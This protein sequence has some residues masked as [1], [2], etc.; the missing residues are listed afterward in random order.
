MKSIYRIL[1]CLIGTG[2]ATT[3]S[4]NLN[5]AGIDAETAKTAAALRD[6]VDEL[7]ALDQ[8]FSAAEKI[9]SDLQTQLRDL[10]RDIAQLSLDLS[11]GETVARQQ[12]QNIDAT[13]K[14]IAAL[15]QQ[16]EAQTTSIKA[17]LQAAYRL[18]GDSLAKSLMQTQSPAEVD[19]LIRY[20]GYF[21][22]HRIDLVE[23][24]SGTLTT[25]SDAEQILAEQLTLSQTYTQTLRE[26]QTKLDASRQER[27]LAIEDLQRQ[28]ADKEQIRS[29][30]VADSERLQALLRQLRARLG[31]LDGTGFAA[32]KGALPRPVRGKQRNRFGA[33]RAAGRMTWQGINFSAREGTSIAAVY[34]G[35]VVFAEWLRGFGLM[36][37]VDHGN[38]YMSLYGNANVLLK[39]PGDWVESGEAVATAGNSGG[40]SQSGLYFE[41]RH[42]GQAQDPAAWLQP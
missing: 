3:A 30:L 39:Q 37:I 15:E 21:S 27:E 13:G 36:T 18:S 1:F 17:H 12:Q 26:R 35:R 23:A 19:R 41:I 14:Q 38:G 9:Q 5:A 7:N 42:K 2:V 4:L 16:L 29:Q 24:Y 6:T 32:A 22:A 33:T 28:S 25:L 8:W 40:Q 31:E 10:D 11:E 20:H 34:Q